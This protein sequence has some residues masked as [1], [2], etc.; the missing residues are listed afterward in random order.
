MQHRKHWLWPGSMCAHKNEWQGSSA[1]S[2]TVHNG[3]ITIVTHNVLRAQNVDGQN[4]N[5][6]KG[7]SHFIFQLYTLG[8]HDVS[9]FG[10]CRDAGGR[11]DICHRK[12]GSCQGWYGGGCCAGSRADVAR[13]R[14][15]LESER[16]THASIVKRKAPT[17]TMCWQ[18]LCAAHAATPLIT[19][20]FS[21]ATTTLQYLHQ[22]I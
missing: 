6:R 14:N 1:S 10:W 22:D 9:S 13:Y 7:L 8:T 11:R 18:V 19:R 3:S 12:A 5:L 17:A 21:T 15:F 16:F 2:P 20:V 4:F